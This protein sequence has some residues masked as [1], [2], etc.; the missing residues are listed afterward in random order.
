MIIWIVFY[1]HRM[2]ILAGLAGDILCTLRYEAFT[3]FAFIKLRHL[4]YIRGI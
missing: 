4:N 2:G 3:V 1:F